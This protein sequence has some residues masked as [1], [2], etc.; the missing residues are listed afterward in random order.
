MSSDTASEVSKAVERFQEL[1]PAL[2][3][4]KMVFALEL[5]GRGDLQVFRVEVPGPDVSKKQPDDARVT[6][7]MPRAT[8]NE[9]SEKGELTDYQ[10][11]W[12]HGDIKSSGDPN[13]QKL[14]GQ[15]VSKQLERARLKKSR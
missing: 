10:Q 14:I 15:V 13:V 3:S 5:R 1:V 6:L 11:A 7:A 12:E 2:A 9:L 4:L 8:F